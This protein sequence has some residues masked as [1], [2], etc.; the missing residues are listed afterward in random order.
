[1]NDGFQTDH[2]FFC[3]AMVYTFGIEALTRIEMEPGYRAV[4]FLDIPTS[5]AA[6]YR[7]E[8]DAGTFAISD[9]KTYLYNHSQVTRIVKDMQRRGES[10]WCSPSWIAGRG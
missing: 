7:R 8:F 3:A 1:M 9:L 2:T 10:S 5:E 6:E 4:F